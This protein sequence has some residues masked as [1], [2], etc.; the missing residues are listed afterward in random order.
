MSKKA[1]A[2]VVAGCAVVGGVFAVSAFAANGRPLFGGQISGIFAGR[3]NVHYTLSL[4]EGGVTKTIALRSWQWGV[5]TQTN[6]P[7]GSSREASAPTFTNLS[8]TADSGAVSPGLMLAAAEGTKFTSATLTVSDNGASPIVIDLD[9]PL[10][11][12]YQMAGSSAGDGG[13]PVD[14]VSMNFTG[15][16]VKTS[17]GTSASWN[18]ATKSSGSTTSVG[19]NLTNISTP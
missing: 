19:W 4:T 3:G 6:S 5:S 15:I 7:S 11:V 17:A 1:I 12:S 18:L 8:F 10:L 14:S 9:Q 13:V 16:S 2:M